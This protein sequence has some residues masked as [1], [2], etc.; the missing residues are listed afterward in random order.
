MKDEIIAKLKEII[1]YLKA[2][3]ISKS[4][5]EKYE[6][7]LLN[8]L[9]ALESQEVEEMSADIKSEAIKAAN[10]SQFKSNRIYDHKSYEDGFIEGAEYAQQSSKVTDEMIKDFSEEQILIGSYGC[11]EDK[12]YQEGVELGA[13]AM[14]GNLIKP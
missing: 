11:R 10:R 9:I 2:I 7:K 8:E 12:I 3:S 1:I 4:P 6:S 14:R 13:K 5:D